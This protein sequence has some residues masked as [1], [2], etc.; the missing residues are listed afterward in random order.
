MIYHMK[1]PI[2]ISNPGV[3]VL[4]RVSVF[5]VVLEASCMF[6]AGMYVVI[7][8]GTRKRTTP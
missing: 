8:P 2:M 5:T 7:R 4:T 6:C 3:R 1:S